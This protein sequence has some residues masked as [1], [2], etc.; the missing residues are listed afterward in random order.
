MNYPFYY[1]F[2]QSS[3]WHFFFLFWERCELRSKDCEDIHTRHVFPW[4]FERR[5]RQ[6]AI[7]TSLEHTKEQHTWIWELI[8][9]NL[10]GQYS[11]CIFLGK[12]KFLWAIFEYGVIA[13]EPDALELSLEYIKEQ[14]TWIWELIVKN[15]LGQYFY[16]YIS[17]EMKISLGDFWI[18]CD[19]P[20]TRRYGAFFGMYQRT[21]YLNLGADRLSEEFAWTVFYVDIFL[22][23]LLGFSGIHS[24]CTCS[25]LERR[26]ELPERSN[27]SLTRR[28][29]RT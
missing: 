2:L 27:W 24:R 29:A 22:W 17:W 25:T 8:V 3:M 9:K 28:V 7:D 1:K 15:L 26:Y 10:L 18:R 23:N 20:W 19:S 4:E 21:T 5:K 12:W 16:V 11:I 6:A 13:L 14:H